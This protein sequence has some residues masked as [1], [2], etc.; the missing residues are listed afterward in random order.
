MGLEN[1]AQT[2][3]NYDP[4]EAETQGSKGSVSYELSWS[5]AE[6]EGFTRL[7]AKAAYPTGIIE[8]MTFHLYLVLFFYHL[9]KSLFSIISW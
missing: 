8:F 2:E 5:E 7:C 1:P 9:D 6:T 4:T 3:K